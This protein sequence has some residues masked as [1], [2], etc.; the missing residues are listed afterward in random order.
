MT[1]CLYPFL[2]IA[3]KLKEIEQDIHM[4]LIIHFLVI[5]L[6][7]KKID[8]EIQMGLIVVYIPS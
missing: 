4:W 3:Q 1:Y 5:Y 6:L 7:L 8:Q 2:N